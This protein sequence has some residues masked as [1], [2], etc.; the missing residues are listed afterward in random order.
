MTSSSAG[1]SGDVITNSD[2]VTVVALLAAN[3][4]YSRRHAV[5]L[6][7]LRAELEGRDIKV[8]VIGVNARYRS[9][10][11]MMSELQRLV[12]FTVYSS[13]SSSSSSSS[14]NYW[15]IMGGL[16][17]DVFIYD[18][19]DRLAYYIPFPRSY[20]PQGFVEAAIQS[21]HSDSP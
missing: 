11:L 3:C 16:K 8:K 14:P 15:S 9:A 13:S 21:A 1:N 12:N 20:V 5:Y 19:C 10:E 6:D 4:G 18:G 7:S 2:H 17:D